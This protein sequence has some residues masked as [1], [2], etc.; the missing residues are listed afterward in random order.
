MAGWEAPR[1]RSASRRG[2]EIFGKVP[3]MQIEPYLFFD[4][5]CDEAIAFYRN[6]L[7]ADV[8]MLTRFKNAPDPAMIRPGTEEKVMHANLRIGDATV[9]VSDGRCTGQPN[10]QGFSLAITAADETEADRVFIALSDGGTVTMPM[11]KTFFSP[12][13]GMLTDR[14]GVGWIV[15][16][17]P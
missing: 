4:G 13:F 9:L 6:A 15:L 5:R 14:F 8:S 3:D 11:G 7:G 12:R 1:A 10:F 2:G 17:R 16:V